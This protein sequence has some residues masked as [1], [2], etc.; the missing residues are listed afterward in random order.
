MPC[1][2]TLGVLF[3]D[4]SLLLT[5]LNFNRKGLERF[6]KDKGTCPITLW[7]VVGP[8]SEGVG[9]RDGV[10]WV[11][12]GRDGNLTHSVELQP[13]RSLGRKT[14]MTLRPTLTRVGKMASQ[15]TRCPETKML[16]A[17]TGSAVLRSPGENSPDRA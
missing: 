14:P 15:S 4:K 11:G 6:Q 13:V 10:G 9:G 5:R 1:L 8:G 16:K 3:L 7:L 12:W 17:P 2:F